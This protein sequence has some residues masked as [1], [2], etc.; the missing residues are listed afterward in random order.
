M[1]AADEHVV[2][3]IAWWSLPTE[4]ALGLRLRVAVVE[5]KLDMSVESRLQGLR[6]LCRN[7]SVI[8]RLLIQK[9]YKTKV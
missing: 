5:W 3:R 6:L 1:R 4:L 8:Q 2:R 9:K 7:T